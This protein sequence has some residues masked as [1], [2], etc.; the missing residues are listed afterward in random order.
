MEGLKGKQEELGKVMEGKTEIEG[1]Y[2]EAI[3]KVEALE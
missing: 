1:L 3:A 2:N